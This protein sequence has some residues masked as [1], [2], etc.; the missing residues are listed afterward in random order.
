[1][2]RK[3][4][5]L[6]VVFAMVA[7]TPV[8]AF[9]DYEDNSLNN[10]QGQAQGQIATEGDDIKT[11]V[12]NAPNTI[13]SDGQSAMGAYSIFGGINVAETEEGKACHDIIIRIS[14][15]EAAGYFTKEEAREEALLAFKQLKDVN[16]PKRLLGFL[17]RTRGRN[18]LNAF[19][20]LAWDDLRFP[21]PE[22]NVKEQTEDSEI[23]DN[24]GVIR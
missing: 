6:L 13:A 21:L 16:E 15:M 9:M 22:I 4:I 24:A 11:Y 5:A 20:L 10:Q 3:V 17:W 12:M 23:I 7:V 18:A 1:M 19:G 8:F 14:Q 2:T